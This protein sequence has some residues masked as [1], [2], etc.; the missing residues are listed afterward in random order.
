MIKRDLK[1]ELFGNKQQELTEGK[2]MR[3]RNQSRILLELKKMI[4]VNI[5]AV[6]IS[7]NKVDLGLDM[8]TNVLIKFDSV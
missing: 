6:F 4:C 3:N 8:D 7:C 5:H 1:I 2:L